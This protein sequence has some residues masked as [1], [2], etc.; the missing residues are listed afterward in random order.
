MNN[1]ESLIERTRQI[2]LGSKCLYK[3]AG[4]EER[5]SNA[6]YAYVNDIRKNTFFY[7]DNT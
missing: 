3:L 7:I 4:Y 1:L 2:M 6:Y 5:A